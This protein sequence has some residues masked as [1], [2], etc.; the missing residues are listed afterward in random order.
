MGTKKQK[1]TADIIAAFK[2]EGASARLKVWPFRLSNG[3]D[4]WIIDAANGKPARKVQPGWQGR[5]TG[6]F[7]SKKAHWPLN[8][9][10]ENE[11]A[12]LRICEY[13][14]DVWEI[15]TQPFTVVHQSD[16]KLTRT[17]PDIE[18]VMSEKQRKIIQVKLERALP[19]PK[20]HARLERDRVAFEACGWSYEIWTDTY[21]RLQPRFETLKTLHYY[22]GN[23][24]TESDIERVRS[25]IGTHGPQPLGEL[26]DFLGRHLP[27]EA[28]LMPLIAQRVIAIDFMRPFDEKACAHLIH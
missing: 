24:P 25:Y 5:S 22:R 28:T 10:S 3:D 9:E 2:A 12:A 11:R 17:Y 8:W 16:G 14:P 13:D 4:G 20:V 18:V 26:R 21:V 27:L 6:S 23:Q 7:A 1:V 19:D 15:R